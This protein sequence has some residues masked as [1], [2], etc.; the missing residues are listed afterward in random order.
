MTSLGATFTVG[1]LT[2]RHNNEAVRRPARRGVVRCGAP[3]A[4][5]RGLG[6]A[7]SRAPGAVTA[8]AGAARPRRENSEL[9]VVARWPQ[10]L[11]RQEHGRGRCSTGRGENAQRMQAV[12]VRTPTHPSLTPNTSNTAPPRSAAAFRLVI[13]SPISPLYSSSTVPWPAQTPLVLRDRTPAPS[14]NQYNHLRPLPLCPESFP[15][16][17]VRTFPLSKRPVPLTMTSPLP[18]RPSR[19]VLHNHCSPSR[20]STISPPL[21]CFLHLLFLAFLTV[22]S[23]PSSAATRSAHY[24]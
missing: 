8:V 13:L 23:F 3:S 4:A 7:H 14:H 17:T 2:A 1:A 20:L 12:A 9:C 22:A 11:E 6:A 18:G 19:P 21:H 16:Q 10:G 5:W 15:P 24:D